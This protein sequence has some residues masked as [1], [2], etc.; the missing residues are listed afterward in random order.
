MKIK[1]KKKNNLKG[2]T[3]VE[4]IVVIAIIGVLAAI[5][6]PNMMGYIQKANVKRAVA[7]AKTVQN[8][9]ATEI[10]NSLVS[11]TSSTS[12]T[13]YSLDDVKAKSGTSTGFPIDDPNEIFFK[14]TLGSNYSGRI[15]DFDYSNSGFE[16]SYTTENLKNIYKVY[17]N[18]ANIDAGYEVIEQSV[19]TVAKKK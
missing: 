16:F 8:V 17:Y 18:K 15:Y 14:D 5:L 10:T 4:L 2:F 12:S 13:K 19:F 1:N 11:D 7:D 9:I 3:L 6:V